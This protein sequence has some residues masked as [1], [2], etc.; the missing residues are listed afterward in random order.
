MR[1]NSNA[2]YLNSRIAAMQV[3]SEIKFLK[4]VSFLIEDI[5]YDNSHSDTVQKAPFELINNIYDAYMQTY[6]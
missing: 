6:I 5:V 3:N 2:S 1:M 4:L